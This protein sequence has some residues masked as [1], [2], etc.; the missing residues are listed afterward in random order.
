ML[1]IYLNGSITEKEIRKVRTEL[2]GNIETTPAFKI[3][4]STLNQR[5][6]RTRLCTQSRAHTRDGH[7]GIRHRRKLI[8]PKACAEPITVDV[9]RIAIIGRRDIQ[10]IVEQIT[11]RNARD[12][13]YCRILRSH[14]DTVAPLQPI[15]ANPGTRGP[16][17]AGFA[18][19]QDGIRPTPF[20]INPMRACRFLRLPAAG[21]ARVE[22]RLVDTT[23]LRY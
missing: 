20:N 2:R 22:L 7:S 18:Q 5:S 3:A 11:R 10:E 1:H 16:G 9:L 14:A 4:L 23:P 12:P 6:Q 19:R 15:P 13:R 21:F 8:C 17:Y